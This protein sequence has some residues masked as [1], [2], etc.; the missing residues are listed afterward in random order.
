MN[1][2]VQE[3]KSQI[4][5]KFHTIFRGADKNYPFL[6]ELFLHNGTKTNIMICAISI[7]QSVFSGI[8]NESITF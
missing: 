8:W 1:S 2:V 3:L 6:P 5:L 4:A 7:F